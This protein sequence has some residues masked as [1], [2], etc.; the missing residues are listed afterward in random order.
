MRSLRLFSLLTCFC[1]CSWGYA[2]VLQLP[3]YVC[4]GR[5]LNYELLNVAELTDSATIAV[6]KSDG[7]LL[8]TSAIT[9]IEDSVNNYRLLIPMASQST[10]NAA[11]YG[12]ALKVTVTYG[13][14]VYTALE[15]FTLTEVGLPG[16]AH[17]HNLVLCTDANN[18]GIAD[19][20]E[21]VMGLLLQEVAGNTN[22][23]FDPAADYDNDGV[24]NYDEYLAGT[25]PFSADDKFTITAFEPHPDDPDLIAITFLVARAKTY[26]LYS[27][28][29]LAD[30][31]G[32]GIADFREIPYGTSSQ[33]YHAGLDDPLTKTIYVPKSKASTL[34]QFFHIK[35]E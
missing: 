35:V 26:Q 18:N 14:R 10:A 27:S 29:E 3:P 25:Y 31:S 2:Q 17:V 19:E 6:A 21:E 28:E 4:V 15:S 23:S 13:G 24:S 16:Q 34:S 12:D 1:L 32:W 11:A 5:I 7:T 9:N 20:Y 8:A 22:A 33:A 30:A